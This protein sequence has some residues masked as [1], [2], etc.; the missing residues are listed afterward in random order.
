[1]KAGHLALSN[2]DSKEESVNVVNLKGWEARIYR[3]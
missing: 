1:L 3:L 2:L